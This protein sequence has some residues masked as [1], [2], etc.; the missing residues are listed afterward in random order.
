MAI[1]WMPRLVLI[2]PLPRLGSCKLAPWRVG[3]TGSCEGRGI[4]EKFGVGVSLNW[5]R[6][7]TTFSGAVQH[8]ISRAG[9]IASA[10][11]FA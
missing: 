4:D 1:S 11:R 7:S 6:W 10:S 3:V 2:Q 8:L 5:C 9:C